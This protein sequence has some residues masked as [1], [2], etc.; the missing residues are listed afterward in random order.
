MPRVFHI[1]KVSNRYW[2]KMNSMEHRLRGLCCQMHCFGLLVNCRSP[3]WLVSRSTLQLF[4]ILACMFQRVSLTLIYLLSDRSLLKSLVIRQRLVSAMV[5]WLVYLGKGYPV[6]PKYEF[7]EDHLVGTSSWPSLRLPLRAPRTR[8][9][10]SMAGLKLL[11]LEF[12]QALNCKMDWMSMDLCES[13][14]LES[15]E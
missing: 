10:A 8:R 3:L 15:I 4:I 14:E 9:R 13:E 7:L 6:F 2:W 1:Q 12:L 5:S 11:L